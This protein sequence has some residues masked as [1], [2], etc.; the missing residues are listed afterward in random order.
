VAFLVNYDSKNKIMR[1]SKIPFCFFPLP[2]RHQKEFSGTTCTFFDPMRM[3]EGQK[4]QCALQKRHLR[5]F[6][7]VSRYS[8]VQT[9]IGICARELSRRNFGGIAS[10]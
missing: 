9:W 7:L 5:D 1:V 4:F 8:V 10:L 6:C 3:V 2:H